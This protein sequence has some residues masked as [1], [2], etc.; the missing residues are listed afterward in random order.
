M[1]LSIYICCLLTSLFWLQT[2]FAQTRQ[3]KFNL[4]E[5]MGEVSLGKV[6]AITQDKDG[7]MWFAVSN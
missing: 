4:V 7:Y 6:N 1:K 3:I 2:G 5:G